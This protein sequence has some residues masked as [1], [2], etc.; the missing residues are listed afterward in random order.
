[1]DFDKLFP[2]NRE[3]GETPLR[4][5]Q[6]VMLRM[7]KIFDYLCA[8]HGI[9]Y[10]LTG[11]SLLGAVRHNGFIPWDDDLDVGMT[12]DNYE[13][14]IQKAV[15]ELPYDIFFQSDETDKYYPSG[16]FVEARLR[17]KYSSYNHLDTANNRW[18][19]G[20][21]VDIFVYDKA[22]LPHNFLIICQNM[23]LNLW[24]KNRRKAR[25]L[26]W[27]EKK[28]RLLPLVY[29]SSYMRSFGLLNIGTF[30]TG[31]EYSTIIKHKFEDIEVSIPKGWKTYLKR[32]YGEFMQLPP[33]HKRTS[34]HKILPQPFKPCEHSEVLNWADR[35]IYQNKF[36]KTPVSHSSGCHNEISDQHQ[37]Y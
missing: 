6:S 20:F 35:K 2:D 21:Q 27:I 30:I 16:D 29:A 13:L 3:L 22:Y 8:R 31:K 17:D 10:F 18:H 24:K 37:K 12:R 33:E 14:F 11:G 34:H 5:C 23:L 26:K 32:Q 15:E 9:T 19:E 4:Q 1:M 36:Q 28:C 7:F 25:I